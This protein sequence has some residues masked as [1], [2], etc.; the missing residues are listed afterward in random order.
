MVSISIADLVF[1]R[2]KLYRG[3]DCVNNKATTAFMVLASICDQNRHV[4]VLVEDLLDAAVI[5]AFPRILLTCG[6]IVG[7]F[8][9]A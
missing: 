5:N 4:L 6:T 2:G 1:R 8:G 7:F 3:S 9:I